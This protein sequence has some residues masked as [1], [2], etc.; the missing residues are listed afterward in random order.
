MM[1]FWDNKK[2]LVTGGHGFL[3]G[4]LVERLKKLPVKELRVPTFGEADLRN[5]DVCHKVVADIDVVI[6]LAALV[7]GI[8][9]NQQH[10]GKVFYENAI[11]GIQ[12]MEEAR[13]AGVKK[14]VA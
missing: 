6:H 5:L 1:K 11:M 12:L 2:V 14:F 13:K 8:G 3:G 9:F 10:P 4:H 7:G